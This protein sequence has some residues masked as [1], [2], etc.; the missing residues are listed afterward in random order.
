MQTKIIKQEVFV[1][2]S[3]PGEIYD[4]FMDSKKHGKLIN[5]SAKISREV[6]GKFEIYDGYITGKNVK[7]EP[8]NKIV[9]LWRGDEECWPQEHYSILTVTFEKKNNG[10]RIK[11]VQENVPEDCYEDFEKGWYE[12]YWEP[13]K[14]IFN[15]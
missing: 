8:N 14:K 6:D 12:F 7:L 15:K 3:S 9:Q 1:D 11:L 5:S 13:L 2:N 4:I 10:T